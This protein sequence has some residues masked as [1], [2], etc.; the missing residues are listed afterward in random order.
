ME[1]FRLRSAW[2][3]TPTCCS[4]SVWFT[5]SSRPRRGFFE[6]RPV[7]QMGGFLFPHGLRAVYT[8]AAPWRSAA[9]LAALAR[10]PGR[11]IRHVKP[12][13]CP[14]TLKTFL[15]VQV[16]PNPR[17]RRSGSL[18]GAPDN[19]TRPLVLGWR[20]GLKNGSQGMKGKSALHAR[21]TL[22]FSSCPLAS[23]LRKNFCDEPPRSRKQTAQNFFLGRE[24]RAA[25][26]T[27]LPLRLRE[28]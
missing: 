15:G 1:P 5:F 8:R 20:V 3:Y 27:R 19:V 11:Y 4:P 25:T 13:S 23:R 10:P 28:G 9:K 21:A 7:C 24:E 22:C 2:W 16:P 18:T 14:H 26:L 6:S 12:F 17:F